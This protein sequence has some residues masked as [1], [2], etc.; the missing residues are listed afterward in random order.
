MLSFAGS[1]NFRN[2]RTRFVTAFSIGLTVA[3]ATVTLI[4]TA[5]AQPLIS[6]TA[7]SGT[8]SYFFALD[9][10][11]F[12][13]PQSYAF[14]YRSNSTSL[15]FSGILQGLS[16][17]PTFSIQTH[18]DPNFG[19]SLDGIA[20]AG[21]VK[22]NVF[23]GA[24]SGEPNGYWSQWNS[25]N[26]VNWKTDDFGIGSQS[27]AAGQWVGASWTAN[28]LT[29]SDAAPRVPLAAIAA[30]EPGTFTL[31]AV[32]GISGLGIVLRRRRRNVGK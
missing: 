20:F 25:P 7:G 21:K 32:G 16:S 30:P 22:F 27:V 26:G 2:Y 1:F 29:V 3:L 10:R 11:D 24:N 14:E 9:F 12:S 13:A 17:V 19:L 31:L 15:L 28:F 23:G 5:T 8:N 6:G 18:V 4:Q